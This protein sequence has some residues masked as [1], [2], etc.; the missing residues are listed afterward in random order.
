MLGFRSM[1]ATLG[2]GTLSLFSSQGAGAATP[3]VGLG[4]TVDLA[5]S[6]AGQSDFT[7]STLPDAR[8]SLGTAGAAGGL[9]VYADDRGVV[10]LHANPAKNITTTSLIASCRNG[11][12]QATT[13]L[14]LHPVA[15]AVPRPAVRPSAPL[16]ALLPANVNPATLSD[17]QIKQ[18]GLPPRPDAAA[19][20]TA[21]TQWLRAMTTAVERVA[22]TTILR[23]DVIHGPAR[24]A[25]SARRALAGAVKQTVFNSNNWSGIVETG[26]TGQF[27]YVVEGEWYV[28]QVSTI[29]S[30]SPAYS[31]LWEGIDG[32]GSGDV[33]Q[34][35]TEQD[36]FYFPF[37]GSLSSYYAWY[38]FYPDNGS[39]QFANFS[40]SP[41]DEIFSESWLCYNSSGQRFGCYFIEDLTK[42]EVAPVKYELGSQPAL[43][44]GN[45]AEWVLERPTVNGSLNPLPYYGSA[46]MTDEF[47]WDSNAGGWRAYTSE[48]HAAVYMY[49]GSDLLSWG[50]PYNSD[51]SY[52]FWAN[53]R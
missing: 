6:A 39:T 29:A 14:R 36:A 3:A 48:N 45:S 37:F 43:F 42:G 40:V 15:H 34:N 35:G 47:A 19:G 41:G 1:I 2:V 18:L 38:E 4:A 33:I 13:V 31:S 5:V 8:C 23:S 22:P 46:Y 26:S 11:S 17:A 53:Y 12:R 50:Y 20:S 16:R 44:R 28:P 24:N 32:W 30:A 7:F 49:N 9:V 52:F 27:N 25:Q 21:Y 51:S 10:R